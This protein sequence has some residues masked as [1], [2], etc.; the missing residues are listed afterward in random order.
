MSD[1]ALFLLELVACTT[2]AA[3]ASLVVAAV[4]TL[5]LILFCIIVQST[6]KVIPVQQYSATRGKLT[7]THRPSDCRSDDK[8][9]QGCLTSGRSL[10]EIKLEGSNGGVEAEDSQKVIDLRGSDEV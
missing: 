5:Y 7:V 9:Q 10:K 8:M 4:P 6:S 3:F 2:L 1:K